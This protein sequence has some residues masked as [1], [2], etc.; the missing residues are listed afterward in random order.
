M[1]D[2]LLNPSK[3]LCQKAR[4]E[5]S[6]LRRIKEWKPLFE[7]S[8]EGIFNLP[9][10]PDDKER[11][12]KSYDY[13]ASSQQ[14]SKLCIEDFARLRTPNQHKSTQKISTEVSGNSK[15]SNPTKKAAPAFTHEEYKKALA[16]L[17]RVFSTFKSELIK[18]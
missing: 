8:C 7:G 17:Q 3:D 2:H 13:S 12:K 9:D 18:I 16:W 15:V 14:E 6:K 1:Y 10:C 11:K 4:N 5:N